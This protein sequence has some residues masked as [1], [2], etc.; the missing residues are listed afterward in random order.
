MA[1]LVIVID[2][3]RRILFVNQ[4][5][6]IKTG[7]KEKELI[8]AKISLLYRRGLE[9]KYTALIQS[10][11]HAKRKWRGELELRTKDG[12]SLCVDA[13]I[14]ALCDDAG[15]GEGSLCIGRD[16]RPERQFS[17]RSW[18]RNDELLAIV[19]SME[20]GVSVCDALGSILMCNAAFALQ[21]GCRKDEI[22]GCAPPY[23][24]TDPGNAVKLKNAFRLLLKEK[25]LT[26]HLLSFCRR[27]GST[28][29][30]SLSLA[31]LQRNNAQLSEIVATTMDVTDVQY[32]QEVRRAT[33]Q[34]YRLQLEVQRKAQRL[35]TLQDVNAFVLNNANVDR[36]FKAITNGIK[37]LVGH[38]LAG[39]Y[40]CDPGHG[41]FFAHTLSKQTPFSRKLAKFPLPMGEGII[42]AAAM[43][44]KLVW[45]NNAQLDPRSRYPAGMRPEKEHF[46]AV[47]LKGRRSIFGILV[48][49]RHR[50]PEFIEEEALVVKSFADAA[51]VALENAQLH[52][53]ATGRLR[54]S[55]PLRRSAKATARVHTQ[56]KLGRSASRKASSDRVPPASGKP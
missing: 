25:K 21:V 27:D 28:I 7:Y 3:K 36:I 44:G 52:H 19:E 4:A 32:A 43:S 14:D 37:N 41:V 45:V 42:G 29:I 40:L 46:I 8:G 47:P 1:E 34:L 50:D 38:D 51:T 53:E 17:Q 11:L 15:A 30:V 24:W 54:E 12:T 13:A 31:R 35:Q 56:P 6:C 33:D 18:E 49:A 2:E 16:L 9:Q 26:N 5:C 20:D 55:P 39:I 23:P 22:V 10:G 48:V